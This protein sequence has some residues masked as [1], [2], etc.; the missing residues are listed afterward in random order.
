M[1]KLK[2]VLGS[3]NS[4]K[5]AHA[6]IEAYKP[7]ECGAAKSIVIKSGK[8]LKGGDYI[9]SRAG[10]MSRRADIIL[11]SKEHPSIR[12]SDELKL[13]V[14]VL[15]K[16]IVD[17]AQFLEPF[18]IDDLLNYA[19][20][21]EYDADVLAYG[22]RTDFLAKSFPGSRRLFEIADDI[23]LMSADCANCGT[24]NANYNARKL[25]DMFIFTGDQ[26][27]IDGQKTE[28]DKEYTYSSLCFHCYK[29]EAH[30]AYESGFN[31]DESLFSLLGLHK[32]RTFV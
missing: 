15:K 27:V 13:G 23:T 18:Q 31:I 21:N 17:E 24:K 6:L 26:V 20:T 28:N 11:G 10:G 16:V 8:D 12:I 9:I 4:A 1:G 22:L 14:L 7:E 32:I 5:T 19:R 30:K 29:Q 25:E 2:A 3:M